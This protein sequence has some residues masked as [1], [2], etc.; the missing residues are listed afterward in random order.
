MN[1]P[2][3]NILLL[4]LILFFLWLLQDDLPK[5]GQAPRPAGG[6]PAAPRT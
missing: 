3:Y 4:T 2:F 5:T 6:P 1:F